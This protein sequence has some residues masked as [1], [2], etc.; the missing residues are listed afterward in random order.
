M[1]AKSVIKDGIA[2]KILIYTGCIAD[3]TIY[4]RYNMPM[5]VVEKWKWYFEYLAA[6]VKKKLSPTES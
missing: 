2:V 1:S 3:E 4:Y 5:R 6:I